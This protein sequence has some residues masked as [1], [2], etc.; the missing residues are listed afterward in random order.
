LTDVHVGISQFYEN[1]SY[2]CVSSDGSK[3]RGRGVGRL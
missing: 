3:I 2:Q 1:T